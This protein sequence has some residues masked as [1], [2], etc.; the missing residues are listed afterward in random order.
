MAD[1]TLAEIDHL[2]CS[3]TIKTLGL[4]TCPTGS[5]D[6]ALDR[7]RLQG[8][9]WVD[10]VLASTLSRRNVWFMVDCQF[11]PK[12]GYGICNNSAS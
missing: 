7:M 12:I 1:E 5:S 3:M 10:R 8:Q 2:P 9:E 11:W 6:A 4:M